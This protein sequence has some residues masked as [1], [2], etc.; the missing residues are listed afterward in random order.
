M[1]QIEKLRKIAGRLG[2]ELMGEVPDM[3]DRQQLRDW[4]AECIG[5][6]LQFD[7]QRFFNLMYRLDI[8]EEKLR[9]A[10]SQP[11]MHAQLLTVAELM[12]D[13]EF[14]RL[15]WWEKYSS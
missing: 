2:G 7:R 13:R 10:L 11:D 14:E 3:D 1:T 6:L 4:L 5:Q 8:R 12:I 15:Y 9:K